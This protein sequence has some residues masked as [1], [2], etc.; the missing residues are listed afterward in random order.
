M[1]KG[2]NETVLIKGKAM[3]IIRKTYL[4]NRTF[5]NAVQR[6]IGDFLQ[7][8]HSTQFREQNWAPKCDIFESDAAI[9]VFIELPGVDE[10][11]VQIAFDSDSGIMAVMGRREANTVEGRRRVLQMEM[12][13]GDFEKVLRV[14]V[15]LHENSILAQL[16]QGILKITLPKY[17]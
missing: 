5:E 2:S 16:S 9:V 8:A 6:A 13:S 7:N 11:D 12:P 15:P 10:R 1:P 14:N 4:G 3:L 17:L